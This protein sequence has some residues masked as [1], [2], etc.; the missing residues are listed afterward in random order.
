MTPNVALSATLLNHLGEEA[1]EWKTNLLK[2]P[3]PSPLSTCSTSVPFSPTAGFSEAPFWPVTPAST[4]MGNK[5]ATE[6]PDPTVR[7]FDDDDEDDYI[8]PGKPLWTTDSWQL[9]PI[10]KA[11]LERTTDLAMPF[12]YQEDDGHQTQDQENK[13][14][15]PDFAGYVTDDGY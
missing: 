3:M 7:F 1:A 9:G 5:I 11:L 13:E 14:A 4:P 12:K 6:T 15:E 10:G 2:E 8:L